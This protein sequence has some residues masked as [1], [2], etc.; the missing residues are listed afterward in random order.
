MKNPT[1]EAP[2]NSSNAKSRHVLTIDVGTTSAKVL[3]VSDEGTV[4]ASAQEFYPTEFPHPGFAVQDAKVVTDGILK[5]IKQARTQFN[6]VIEAIGVSSAMHSMMAIDHEGSPLTPLILWSDMRSAAQAKQLQK[7][8]VGIEIYNATGTPIHPMSP[9]C[10]LMWMRENQPDVLQKASKFISIKEYLFLILCGQTHVDYSVASS[11]GLFDVHKLDWS[12]QALDVA[13]ITADKLS[14]CVSPY[15]R[16]LRIRKDLAKSLGLDESIPVVPGASD[17]CLAHLGSNAMEKGRLSLTVGTSGAVRMASKT[18]APDLRQRTFNY[19]LDEHTFISGG[20]TN[21]GTVLLNWFCQNFY[22]GSANIVDFARAA[23][24]VDA[25][26][27]G[28]VFL[29]YVFGERAPHYNPDLRGV[30]FGLAQHHT[31]AHLMRALLEGICLEIRSIVESIEQSI[32]QVTG[33]LASGGFVRS[34]E[35]LQIMS[36]VLQKSITLHDV[37][38][39]SSLGAALIA[40]K[41]VGIPTSFDGSEK[42]VVFEPDVRLEGIYDDLYGI[43]SRTIEVVEKEFSHIVRLQHS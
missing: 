34:R 12:Q 25:G 6:G 17:G 15:D 23:S 16:T 37:H 13:G 27:G 30:F 1:A 38:D 5:I 11:S 40:F 18:Y 32:E 3:V 43:F 33:I 28:L 14:R 21:N 8:V 29:P 36:N 7:S 9:L 4:A 42:K 26:A 24:A 2:S 41:S 20:A 19:R 35:W 22:S 31:Q 39:A 10:K